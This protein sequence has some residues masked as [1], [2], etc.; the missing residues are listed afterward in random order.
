MKEP[1]AIILCGFGINSELETAYAFKKAGAKA[2][3]IHFSDLEK[4]PSIFEESQ[5]FV[6]PGG[7]S[8]ADQIQ[9]G[10]ILANKLRFKLY[11]YFKKF[12]EEKKAVLGICN[13][14]QILVQ[15]GALPGWGDWKEKNFSLITNK[16]GKFED[17]W[18]YLRTE[19]TVC[20]FSNSLA[21]CFLIPIRHG[22]GR[23][24]A[25]NQKVLET[26]EEKG[27]IVFRY[28]NPD[29]LK[30]YDYPFNPNGS[31]ESI[32]GI[33]NEYGNVLGLMPHP[34]CHIRIYQNPLWTNIKKRDN[35]FL[36][37]ILNFFSSSFIKND[38][39]PLFSSIVNYSKKFI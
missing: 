31:V 35:S 4:N 5:I 12:I 14:F 34:E 26:L 32:A 20:P 9:S 22:E 25:K 39:S 15:L 11:P 1:T 21:E 24:I 17:R 18:V 33:C 3:L 36:S 16:S 27:Q 7:W 29:G 23:F 19:R 37:K 38:C 13:G 6:L 2:L 28:A 10:K 30:A 8:Y